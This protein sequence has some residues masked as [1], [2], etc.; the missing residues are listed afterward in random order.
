MFVWHLGALIF[1]ACPIVNASVFEALFSFDT[2]VLFDAR[3]H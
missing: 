2:L 1:N 3:W